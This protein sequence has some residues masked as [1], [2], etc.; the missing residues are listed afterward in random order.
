M[1]SH[2]S[3]TPAAFNGQEDEPLAREASR[4][5]KIEM[6][7]RDLSYK[8]LADLMGDQAGEARESTQA[9]TNKINRGRFSF[10]FFLR[11]CRAMGVTKLDLSELPEVPTRPA[12]PK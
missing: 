7:R 8:T 11:A 10:A 12:R 6:A 5:L 4:F 9:L 2:L 1:A 3:R